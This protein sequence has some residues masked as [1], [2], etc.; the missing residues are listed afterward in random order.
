MTILL[1]NH[2][3]KKIYH[4]SSVLISSITFKGSFMEK[5]L[6]PT[7]SIDN[8]TVLILVPRLSFDDKLYSLIS[9]P[10]IELNQKTN[11]QGRCQLLADILLAE[12]EEILEQDAQASM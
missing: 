10:T 4:F 8:I 11:L 7:L 1:F 3:H 2:I 9:D 12:P 6:E 5:L